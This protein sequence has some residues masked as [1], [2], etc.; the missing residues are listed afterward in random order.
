MSLICGDRLPFRFSF[1]THN[2]G[3]FFHSNGTSS[4]LLSNTSFDSTHILSLSPNL[5]QFIKTDFVLERALIVVQPVGRKFG[6]IWIS[7]RVFDIVDHSSLTRVDVGGLESG[8]AWQLIQGD[9]IAVLVRAISSFFG[10]VLGQHLV[11]AVS[12]VHV[13]EVI[14]TEDVLW[15][16]LH[17]VEASVV[18]SLNVVEGQLVE[19]DRAGLQI[20]H[21]RGFLVGAQFT[22]DRAARRGSHSGRNIINAARSGTYLRTCRSTIFALNAGGTPS[23]QRLELF[24]RTGRFKGTFVRILLTLSHPSWSSLLFLSQLSL[25]FSN[26]FPLF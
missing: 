12:R 6:R 22:F 13:E 10:L 20:N 18:H 14:R 17:V 9:H 2:R 8:K 25:H 26:L 16:L 21:R 11:F 19:F 7:S 23:T 5:A 15:K 3:V 24:G 1:A 4:R